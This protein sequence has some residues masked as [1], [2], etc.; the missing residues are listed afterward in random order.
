MKL[1]EAKELPEDRFEQ[2]KAENNIEWQCFHSGYFVEE[3][4]KI[5]G[6][7]ELMPMDEKGAFWLKQLYIV[8]EEAMKLPILLEH[9]LYFAKEKNATIL[10]AHSEQPVTDLLLESLRFSYRGPK[11]VEFAPLTEYKKGAWWAYQYAN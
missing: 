1:I 5:I 3:S 11:L 10:Y 9:I 8:R 2:F 6:C 4:Q 7:F